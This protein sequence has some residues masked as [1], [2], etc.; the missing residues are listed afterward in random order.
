MEESLSCS[1]AVQ[2]YSPMDSWGKKKVIFPS[3]LGDED[4]KLQ[5]NGFNIK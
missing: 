3:F 4:S 2:P 5:K 1:D